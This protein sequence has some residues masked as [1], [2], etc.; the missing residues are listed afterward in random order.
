M[1]PV[2]TI[3][4]VGGGVVAVVFAVVRMMIGRRTETGTGISF[5]VLLRLTVGVSRIDGERSIACFVLGLVPREI[6][7]S[8]GGVVERSHV[9]L[10]VVVGGRVRMWR[11]RRM[12][13]V[14]TVAMMRIIC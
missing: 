10:T 8:Q 11:I 4:N 9:D 7:G 14:V 2:D 13:A 5:V 3:L 6:A 12:R 1:G